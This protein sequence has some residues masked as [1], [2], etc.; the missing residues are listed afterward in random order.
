MPSQQVQR[1]P[2]LFEIFNAI[3]IEQMALFKQLQAV[4]NLSFDPQHQGFQI[5]CIFTSLAIVL[6]FRFNQKLI[7]KFN[8]LGVILSDEQNM[9]EPVG[10]LTL[11]KSLAALVDHDGLPIDVH[12]HALLVDGL[13]VIGLH[14]FD[15]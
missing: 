6:S 4:V 12:C 13:V 9:N 3:R 7:Y 8:A 2:K 11:I 14:H 1:S 15:F 10:G 5:Y